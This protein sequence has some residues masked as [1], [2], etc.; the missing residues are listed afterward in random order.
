MTLKCIIWERWIAAPFEPVVW[1]DVAKFDA[2]WR[3][4][5][6]Y[7]GPFGEPDS[8]PQKYA[9]IGN[10]LSEGCNLWMPHVGLNDDNAASFTD[11]RHRFAW[12]RDH[13]VLALPVT[14]GEEIEAEIQER[15]GSSLRVTE[16][17]LAAF[18][19]R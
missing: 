6:A 5:F 7:V 12:L 1:I 15:F 16:L 4:D 9:R 14:C 13:G 19:G 18:E 10:W 11:G 17:P 3:N 8:Q 2:S